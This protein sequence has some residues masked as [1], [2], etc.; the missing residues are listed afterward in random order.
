MILSRPLCENNS[1]KVSTSTT[2]NI[3]NEYHTKVIKIPRVTKKN[4]SAPHS[5]F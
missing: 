5:V 2:K 3:C 4:T 1:A